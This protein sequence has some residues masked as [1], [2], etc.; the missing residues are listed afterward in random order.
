MKKII[1]LFILSGFI[2]VSCVGSGKSS[3]QKRIK[4]QEK[5]RKKHDCPQLDC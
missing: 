3:T 1:I 4:K 5:H 2:A